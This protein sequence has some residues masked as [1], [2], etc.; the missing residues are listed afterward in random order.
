[1]ADEKGI[2]VLEAARL[3]R[4]SRSHLRNLLRMGVIRGKFSSPNSS[5]STLKMPYRKPGTH[6]G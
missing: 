3:S 1:M 4:L 2:T 5:S 6:D